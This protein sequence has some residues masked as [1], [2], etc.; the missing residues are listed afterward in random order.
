[1]VW[2]QSHGCGERRLFGV[3]V[4]G[5]AYDVLMLL[6]EVTS[7]MEFRVTIP[8]NQFIYSDVKTFCRSSFVA[9]DRFDSVAAFMRIL[10]V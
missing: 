5:A 9:M 3:V 7:P 4:V 6:T 1:M 10:S 2:S 8:D